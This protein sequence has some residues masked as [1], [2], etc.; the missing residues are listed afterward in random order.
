MNTTIILWLF[1][2]Y[3]CGSI[4]FGKIISQQYG[5][6]I[7]KRGSGNIGFANVRRIVGWKAGILTLTGDILKGLLPTLITF[8]LTDSQIIAYCVGL[9]AI[10]GHVFPIW[11]QGKGGKGIATGFGVIAVLYPLAAM[12]GGITYIIGGLLHKKSSTASIAGIG[13]A[14]LVGIFL[15][16]NTYWQLGLLFAL[17]LFTLRH[18]LSN[19]VPNHDC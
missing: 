15:A 9:A 1:F 8:Q 4:P 7:Q 2:G 13:V 3:I 18:N 12:A 6:N 17:S 10:V 5:V 11:L 14:T 19:R 16:P